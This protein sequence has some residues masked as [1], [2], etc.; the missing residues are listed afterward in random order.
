MSDENKKA[1]SSMEPKIRRQIITKQ[2]P[3]PYG[4]GHP[5]T[6]DH[7]VALEVDVAPAK[8]E[9]V[10]EEDE[11]AS[12]HPNVKRTPMSPIGSPSQRKTID[13]FTGVRILIMQAKKLIL[14]IRIL[15]GKSLPRPTACLFPTMINS[16]TSK[17]ASS[18][19]PMLLIQKVPS[20]ND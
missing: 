18:S 8:E 20:R 10:L 15:L 9:E 11:D 14:K 7:P 13:M 1:W 2:N 6:A 17:S 19:L 12:I 4:S 16:K 5:P 3:N